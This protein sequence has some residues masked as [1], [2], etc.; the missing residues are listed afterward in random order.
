MWHSHKDLPHGIIKLYNKLTISLL[1]DCLLIVPL[2]PTYI[3]LNAY[4]HHAYCL[5]TIIA[6]N[7]QGQSGLS[8]R[9]PHFLGPNFFF[10]C[11]KLNLT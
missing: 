6:I 7:L 4:L 8:P 10:S 9:F 1:K 3:I 2:L 11:T 5:T